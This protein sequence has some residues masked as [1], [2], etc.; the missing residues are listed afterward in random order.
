MNRSIVAKAGVLLWMVFGLS[1]RP[2]PTAAHQ[3]PTH[4][5]SKSFPAACFFFEPN[6]DD[7][8]SNHEES[9]KARDYSKSIAEVYRLWCKP[10][11]SSAQ[12]KMKAAD[13]MAAAWKLFW[14]DDDPYD[15]VFHESGAIDLLALMGI[16]RQIPAP[17]VSDPKFARMWMDACNDSCFTINNDMEIP[18]GRHFIIMQLRLR[19][20]VLDNLKKEPASEPVIQMLQNARFRL[21]D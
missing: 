20:D 18:A 17:M 15:A 13:T 9:A 21:V 3:H 19:N 11:A 12:A 14:D 2:V 7:D 4:L 10:N 1:V 16:T 8:P 6:K 5:A